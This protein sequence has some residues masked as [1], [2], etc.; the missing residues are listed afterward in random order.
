M[1]LLERQVKPVIE[2]KE[3][4]KEPYSRLCAALEENDKVGY[5][6]ATGTGKSYVGGK[7]VEDHGLKDKTLI[8][9]PSNVIRDGWQKILPG[10][11]TMTYQTLLNSEV[12][13]NDYSLII[14]DEMHHLGAE[15]W[16]HS[17]SEKT[18]GFSG[19][20]LGM[21]ATPIRFLDN[22]RNM[23]EEMFEG[24]RVVG[25]ELPEAIEKGILP[26]FDYIAVL[27]DLS[28]LR[29]IETGR[30]RMLTEKL[31]CQLDVMENEHSF[32]KIIIK[33]MKPGIHKVCVFVPSIS[34][35]EEYVSVVKGVYPNAQHYIAHSEMAASDIQHSVEGFEQAKET[36]FLY[37]VD[38]LNEGV[39]IDG[40]DT[41][42][43]FRK[44]ESPIIFLQQLGR[45]L[46]TN[47]AGS[48]ITV[49]DFVSNHSNIR[50][51]EK[52]T[53][54]VIEWISEGITDPKK[55]I[56]KTDYAKAE[57][58][59][60][61]KLSS[62]LSFVW[63]EW[64][65]D[66]IRQHYGTE[67]GRQKLL[68]LLPD[69]SWQCIAQEAS[70]LGLCRHYDRIPEEVEDAIKTYYQ[71]EDGKEI[72]KGKYPEIAWEK[73]RSAAIRLGLHE[74]RQPLSWS[75]EEDEIIKCNAKDMQYLMELL[76]HRSAQQIRARRAKLGLAEKKKTFSENGEEII[77]QNK[78]MSTSEMQKAFFPEWSSSFI[79][80][81]RK[82][83]D[84]LP[85]KQ[86]PFWTKET[87]EE[88]KRAYI[89]GGSK[90][91]MDIPKFRH[92]TRKQIGDRAKKVGVKTEKRANETCVPFSDAETE[93]LLSWIED[94]VYHE[95]DEV[96]RLFPLHT[97]GSV[98][99]KMRKLKKK[100]G[101][102]YA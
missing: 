29:P 100:K 54:S 25:L 70:V 63:T 7:Y 73:I 59:V 61:D 64:E 10:V 1:H 80:S 97:I 102:A 28:S 82:E 74:V 50:A 92:M 76:P 30:N 71:M 46:T 85:D 90:A 40:V 62:L 78:H 44:T 22:R 37:T 65:K 17:F 15:Q 11:D 77:L 21:S 87:N 66:V 47:S 58:E 23:I 8:L 83:L 9:V 34:Q 93:V 35:I 6:S 43:M 91:V 69:R 36:C 81:K 95:D 101:A 60:L 98:R 96:M 99:V 79:S 38:L 56:I 27:Y 88:F 48:R 19:K 67:T 89:S 57:Q 24:N 49:F 14:C 5:E 26:T 20:L 42:I 41:I 72:I 94:G 51:R 32:Q 39:H 13:F 31:Y 16:G 84:A 45:A 55:Q 52:G 3:H 53:G 12:R 75:D 4:N 2:L 86:I 68:E 33:H 18:V